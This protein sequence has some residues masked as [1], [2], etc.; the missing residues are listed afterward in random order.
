MI[1]E[2]SD[3]RDP[4]AFTRRKGVADGWSGER[5]K[6]ER[7]K[8]LERAR[9]VENGRKGWSLGKG[10]VLSRK[11]MSVLSQLENRSGR[12]GAGVI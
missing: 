10:K 9:E 12:M 2:S 11:I 5:K 7:K 4:F 3:L 1:L 8:K 6:R